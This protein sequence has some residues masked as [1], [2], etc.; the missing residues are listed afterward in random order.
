M[1]QQ[2]VDALHRERRQGHRQA[3]GQ[4]DGAHV[5]EPER[6]LGLGRLTVANPLDVF[7]VAD[8]RDRHSDHGALHASTHVS[9]LPPFW[10]EFTTSAPSSNATRVRP[11]GSTSTVSPLEMAKGR[12]S[13]CR[14][15][16]RPLVTV[17]WSESMIVSWAMNRSGALD[18]IAAVCSR[19]SRLA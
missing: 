18:S 11:P 13:M 10:E 19:S 7:L 6:H 1:V 15:S 4:L 5:R 9:L 2:R 12:R 3:A 16:R 8:L 17:G 14:I